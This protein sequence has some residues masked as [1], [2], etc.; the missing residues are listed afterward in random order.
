[1]D[2]EKKDLGTKGKS[3]TLKGKVNQTAGK[4]QKKVGQ[5]TGDPYT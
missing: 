4:V 1:M 5:A 2:E 3:D